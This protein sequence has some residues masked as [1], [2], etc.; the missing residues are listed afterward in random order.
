VT[1]PHVRI[2]LDL[3][4]PGRGVLIAP[5]ELDQ[6]LMNLILNARDAMPEGGR[7]LVRTGHATLLRPLAGPGGAA[8]AGRYAVAEVIDEGAGV[9]PDAMPRLFEPFFT[10]RAGAGGNG[11]GLSAVRDILRD[12]GGCVAVESVPGR[13]AFRVYLPSREPPVAPVVAPAAGPPRAPAERT[14]LLAEDEEPV[15]RLAARTLAARGWTVIEADSGEAALA[16]DPSSLARVEAV[17]AD[18]AM[19]GLDGPALIARLRADRPGLPAVLVSGY[20]KPRGG[21]IV[22]L[23]KPYTL[24]ALAE[25]LE[26]A[27]APAKNS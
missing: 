15:R 26:E 5:A 20:P 14:V 21:D 7:I 12:R 11:V 2:E 4:E 27:V 23:A 10:T 1:G 3:E 25:A 22:F 19:P 17:V 13:T 8:P 16:L 6:V 24:Q 18:M 9:A